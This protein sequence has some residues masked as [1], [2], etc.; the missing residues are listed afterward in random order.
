MYLN[1]WTAIGAYAAPLL[2]RVLYE[3]KLMTTNYQ[4]FTLQH[5]LNDDQIIFEVFA[6][7][8][9]NL[10]GGLN[11]EMDYVHIT[12]NQRKDLPLGPQG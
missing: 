6:D 9:L 3:F 12:P 8:G 4:V 5:K 1:N 7:T 10:E 2:V 11:R